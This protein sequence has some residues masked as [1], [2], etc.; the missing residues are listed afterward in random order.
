MCRDVKEVRGV[1]P[2]AAMAVGKV[3]VEFVN[4]PAAAPKLPFVGGS[5]YPSN[6]GQLEWV[7]WQG[8][9]TGYFTVDT[10]GTQGVVG[11]VPPRGVGLKDVTMDIETPFAFSVLT[12][13]GPKES[14]R[15]AKSALLTVV[16]RV[17]NSGM[18][19]SADGK[20]LEAV[21]TAPLL[22]EPVVGTVRVLRRPVREVRVLDHD[23]RRTGR[24]VPVTNGTFTIDGR[25]DKAIYYEVVFG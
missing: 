24:T 9:D 14:L 16:A 22:C 19:Y 17:H 3:E 11:H 1:V 12:A 18:K 2:P 21:G 8:K 20:R 5:I 10:P 13:L 6:T 25:R 15:T 7:T 4:R 23:G